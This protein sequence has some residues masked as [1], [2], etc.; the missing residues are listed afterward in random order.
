M[1]LSFPPCANGPLVSCRPLPHLH[2]RVRA[3]LCALLVA[4][5]SALRRQEVVVEAA[6]G[7]A[8][9]IAD[10]A[11]HHV[12]ADELGALLGVLLDAEGQVAVGASPTGEERGRVTA[13][14]G[15]SRPERK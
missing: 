4:L 14:W 11:Y 10:P 1:E 9:L 13:R 6:L 8:A 12:A 7:L 5:V 2:S 15:R 3:A